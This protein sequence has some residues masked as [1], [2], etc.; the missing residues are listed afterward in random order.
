[1]FCFW[2]TLFVPEGA[3]FSEANWTKIGVK[4]RKKGLEKIRHHENTDIHKTAAFQYSCFISG[5]DIEH[6]LSENAKTGRKG[7]KEQVEKNRKVISTFLARQNLA[8]RGHDESGDSDN[9]VS[10]FASPGK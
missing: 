3:H 4:N 6:S 5:N 8:F 1:M 7:K 2:C 10:G 9:K